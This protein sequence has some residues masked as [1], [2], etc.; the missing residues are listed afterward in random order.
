[1]EFQKRLNQKYEE[2]DKDEDERRLRKI[3]EDWETILYG[4]IIRSFVLLIQSFIRKY[5]TVPSLIIT[6]K[7][8]VSYYFK[9]PNG[10]KILGIGAGKFILNAPIRAFQYPTKNCQKTGSM[11]VFR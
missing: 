1:M 10:W 9:I 3:E 4:P 8:F 2:E 6:K 7:S 11:R 5:I